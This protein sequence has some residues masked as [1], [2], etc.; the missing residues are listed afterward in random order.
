MS[1]TERFTRTETGQRLLRCPKCA[2]EIESRASMCEYCGAL[3]QLIGRGGA[4]GLDGIVCF[5]CGEANRWSAD[6]AHCRGCGRPFATTCPGCGE[7][8]PLDRRLC[9]GCRLSVEQFDVERA[10]AVVECR[11]ERR[12]AERFSMLCARWQAFVGL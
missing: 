1:D 12:E 4:F 11:R 3:V 9:P 2:A 6:G 7:G 5:D 8:V 10:R